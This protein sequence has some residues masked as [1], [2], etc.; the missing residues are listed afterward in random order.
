MI[1][2]VGFELVGTLKELGVTFHHDDV[3]DIFAETLARKN[4]VVFGELSLCR[5]QPSHGS[6]YLDLH[7]SLGLD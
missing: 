7:R 2:F 4:D 1:T 6:R 5:F 3:R